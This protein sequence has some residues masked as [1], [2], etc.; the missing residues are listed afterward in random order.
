MYIHTYVHKPDNMRETQKREIE[1]SLEKGVAFFCSI[2]LVGK[3]I[4]N[5]LQKSWGL[6]R[7]DFYLLILGCVHHNC[8]VIN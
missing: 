8:I 7:N 4:N 2:V 6:G 3:L 5:L 1:A